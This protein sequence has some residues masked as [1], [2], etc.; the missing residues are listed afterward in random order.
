MSMGR[1]RADYYAPADWNAQCFECG[2]KRKATTLLRH[3]KGY[4]VCQE[5]WEPRQPQDFVQGI[6]EVIT[7][8]WTQPMPADDFLPICT[9]N[10]LSAVPL[11]AEP[12]CMV[13][14]YLSPAFNPDGDPY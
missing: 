3:W 6:P 9:P 2:R 13:P 5:H 1:G 14:G 10:G 7:P 11:F 8:P 12:G 4:W